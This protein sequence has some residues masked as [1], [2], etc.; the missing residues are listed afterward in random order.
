MIKVA[1]EVIKLWYGIRQKFIFDRPGKVVKP[2]IML[3]I[4]LTIKFRA[5]YVV[6]ILFEYEI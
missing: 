5:R 6:Q 3:G 2:L 4:K 1:V